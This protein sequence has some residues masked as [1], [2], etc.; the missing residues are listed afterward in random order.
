MPEVLRLLSDD[1][2]GELLWAP[3]E[4]LRS[5]P[6]LASVVRERFGSDS[7]PTITGSRLLETA[8]LL[9]DPLDRKKLELAWVKRTYPAKIELEGKTIILLNNSP[10]QA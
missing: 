8:G 3:L 7:F 4:I 9:E 2:T 6:G 5:T 10:G 1:A